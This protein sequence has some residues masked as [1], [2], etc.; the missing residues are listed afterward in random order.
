MLM[1]LVVK[2][3]MAL[4]LESILYQC[5][6]LMML[7]LPDKLDESERCSMKGKQ[8]CPLSIKEELDLAQQ[9]IQ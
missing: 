1:L 3:V 9:D 4:P 2:E 6:K 7:W 5:D 8:L